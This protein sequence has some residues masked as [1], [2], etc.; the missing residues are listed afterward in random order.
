MDS[1]YFM[2]LFKN[3]KNFSLKEVIQPQVPLQLPCY[4][5]TPVIASTV[6]VCL[7]KG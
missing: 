5:F 7:Q 6:V 2:D 3:L 4:D 1:A